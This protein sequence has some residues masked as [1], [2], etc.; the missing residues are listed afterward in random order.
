M[1]FDAEQQLPVFTAKIL[2]TDDG[3]KRETA[4]TKSCIYPS[5]TGPIQLILLGA[6]RALCEAQAYRAEQSAFY[7]GSRLSRPSIE[8]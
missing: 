7:M 2:P 6:I 4:L 3:S 1:R 5:S 8:C